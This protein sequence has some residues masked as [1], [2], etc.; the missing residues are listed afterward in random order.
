VPVTVL[1]A[2]QHRPLSRT[3]LRPDADELGV[4]LRERF[5]LDGFRPGQEEAI[6]ALLAGRDAL[7]VMPT[8]AGKS[9]IYQLPAHVLPGLTVVVSPLI[10][11][12]KDQTDKLDDLGV[13][14]WSVNSAQSASERRAAEG[15]MDRG[16]GTLLYLTPERFRDRDFF[17]RL[18]EREVSLL[19][20]DEA[21][22]VSQWGHDF[23]PDYMMLGSVAER[24]GRPPVLALTATASPEVRDDIARQL[25][26]RDPFEWIGEPIRPN[27]FLE[28][29]PTVNES[30][31]D[32]ALDRLLRETPGPGIVYVATVKEAERIHRAFGERHA[33][34]LYHGRLGPR[35]RHEA[36]DRFMGGEAKAVVATNAFGLGIDKADIRLIVHYHFPGSLESYY[37]EAGRAGRDGEPSRCVILYREEDRGVQGYF[38]G[39]R[40]PGLDEAIAVARVVN[41]QPE[42][43]RRPL[44]EI[45]EFAGVPRRKARIVLTLLKRHGMVREHRGGVWERLAPDV[46]AA[47][48]GRELH[49]YEE[50]RAADRTKLD[51]M[52]R[53]CRTAGCRTRMIAEYLG[54]ERVPEWR[55]GHCNGCVAPAAAAARGTARG[56]TIEPDA[57]SSDG[58]EEPDGPVSVG[59]EVRHETFGRGL[60]LAVEA[61]RAEVDFERHGTRTLGIDRL[62]RIEE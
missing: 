44:D 3:L 24:L 7:V 58:N 53:Y 38:L 21:H 62:T 12:M 48:L 22:C 14:A 15:A 42:G 28:V 17:E 32:A 34:A 29:W 37:Q 51:D 16:E 31:K 19:V 39:G 54:D 33:L 52:V 25:R 35:E 36:Q 23:R 61:A 4:L 45:A 1:N 59:D 9:L 20:V 55:C 49:D 5:A 47:D 60:V 56:S 6:H 18:L 40:Y 50:R 46:T 8:G 57:P 27:L 13:D 30:A 41:R 10:A 43:D 11:L 2:L 26:L